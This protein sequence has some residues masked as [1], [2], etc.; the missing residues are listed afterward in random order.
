MEKD[1]F[2]KTKFSSIKIEKS[3]IPIICFASKWV[4]LLPCLRT[5]EKSTWRKSWVADR[6]LYTTEATEE[7][8]GE[9]YFKAFTN[10]SESPSRMKSW[11]SRSLAKWSPNS[12]AFASISTA[13][14][15]AI[16]FLLRA[17]TTLPSA[18]LTRTPRPASFWDAKTAPST[19]IL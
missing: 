9:I 6:E 13:P 19:L 3:A 17:P 8:G 2:Y 14:R 18:S 12:K 15:G 16:I 4:S 11:M 10:T 7:W 5:W 1:L